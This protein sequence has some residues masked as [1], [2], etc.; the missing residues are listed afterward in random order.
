MRKLTSNGVIESLLRKV[1]SLIRGV[2]NLVV[3]D[4]EVEGKT[5][6]DGM[7]GRKISLGNVG[8]GS[9]G[10]ER[11]VGGSL[12]L[13]AKSELGKITVVVTLPATNV[14]LCTITCF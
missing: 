11:L 9:V 13:V 3:E 8:S 5:E 10:L 4:G 2:E 14:S 12:A 1:A 6:T 7:C